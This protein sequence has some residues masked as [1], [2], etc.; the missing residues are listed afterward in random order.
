MQFSILMCTYNSSATL[1]QAID[2]VRRQSFTDW[3]LVI[4]DNGST[5]DTVNI[6][7]GYE[8]LDERIICSYRKENIGWP[9]GIS[10]CLEQ[11]HGAYMM[12][13]GA[14]DLIADETVLESV[15]RAIRTCQPEVV[16]TGYGLA[17][18]E[19]GVHKIVKKSCPAYQVY[20][21]RDRVAEIAE[22]MRSVYYNSVMHYVSVAFLKKHG[23]DFFEPF[24][25]D[26]MGMT[27]AMCK[28]DTMVVLDK[29]AYILT[30]NT[31]QTAGRTGFD[32]DVERQWNSIKEVLAD[33]RGKA[34]GN[35]AYIA[36]RIF[37]NL[38]GMY[39]NVALGGALRNRWMNP[40]EKSLPDRFLKAEEWISTEA[41]GEMLYYSGR[42]KYEEKL[43][44]AAGVLYWICQRQ[45]DAAKMLNDRSLWLAEYAKGA[46]VCDT[47]GNV[48]W[49][50]H[51]SSAEAKQLILVLES[52]YNRHCIGAE[53]LLR[54]EVTYEDSADRERIKTLRDSYLQQM[55]AKWQ[56]R[57]R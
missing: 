43:L 32:Y 52:G 29:M 7:Q 5:D 53:M 51:F 19:D 12:F 40:V 47:Q 39:E 28:A 36:E 38:E 54:E 20:Y 44:G 41:F 33:S 22:L 2:S 31:S 50:R 8:R 6:L 9:K 48:Q 34:Y 13:L 17:V 3:E 27:E 23:I 35:I 45:Q 15:D 26:C 46:F 18:F 10:L 25:G 57:G 4:I 24:Y 56:E 14:D 30:A 21:G 11:V 55:Q 49:K 1:K 42:R 16:W 37:A